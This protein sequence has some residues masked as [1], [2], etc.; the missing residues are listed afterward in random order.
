MPELPEVETVRRSLAPEI[1]GRVVRAVEVRE[2]RLRGG[3]ARSF[4]GA[5][6]GRR[7]A[8]LERRGKFLLAPLDDGRTWL[9]H[10]GMSGR[11]TL[12]PGG[13][14]GRRHDHV[15][16]TLDD[17]RA[18]VYNDPRR[19]GRMAV[20]AP[21]RAAAEVG[22]GADP[23]AVGFTTEALH[24]LTRR[25]RASIKALLMDQRRIAGVGNIYANEIL[26]HAGIRPRRRAGRL[27][28][29][30]CARVVAA[31]R[32]VLADAIAKGGS[33]ISDYRDGFG[34]E[35]WFQLDLAVY[36]R[37]GEPCRR[38]G[39]A[40]RSCVVVGRSTFYCPRCQR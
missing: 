7:L 37:A 23:L 8:G 2:R 18:L 10:L 15:V 35:G 29:A 5:L 19:F 20:L 27:G 17:G 4:A 3:V 11:L 36:D 33:S 9:M 25:R 28:R 16:V 21:A 1:V 40:V 31:T 30:D 32:A 39:G 6:R 12:G 26:F 38:C 34:R 22:E 13:A 24:A 14:P